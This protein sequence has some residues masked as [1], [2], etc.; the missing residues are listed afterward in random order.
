MS[1]KQPL[2]YLTT[3]TKNTSQTLSELEAQLAQAKA[4]LQLIKEEFEQFAY[5]VS[6]DLRG[7]VRHI[8]GY[9]ELL[10]RKYGDELDESG[11]EFLR[12]L[13]TGAQSLNLQIQAILTFSR[14]GRTKITPES[15]DTETHIKQ[16]L[17]TY[18]LD[19]EDRGIK[20]E[21]NSL[22]PIISDLTMFRK[23]WDQ[24][25][26]NAIRF[27]H[28]AQSPHIKIIAALDEEFVTFSIQDNGIGFSPENADK[29]FQFFSNLHTEEECPNI[30]LGMG[31]VFVRKMVT[32]LG[33]K[34]WA[35]S[36]LNK[37]ATFYLKLP[38]ALT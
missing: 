1:H 31:L 13:K 29:L 11:R 7:P 17:Q 26:S 25:V 37:G 15:I 12:F 4:E 35:K 10:D 27:T 14:I 19:L 3:H 33:G 2:N 28:L 5:I 24:L 36:E 34:I 16:I 30:G 23:I 20:V 18:S 6:H 8:S 32:I 21:I 9:A 38:V 22:P